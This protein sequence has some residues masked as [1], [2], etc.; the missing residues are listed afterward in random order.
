VGRK[1]KIIV[2]FIDDK[3]PYKLVVFLGGSG[4]GGGEFTFRSI[5]T[6]KLSTVEASITK[7]C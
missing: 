7:R 6:L 3:I 4:G 2:L 5:K 1:K